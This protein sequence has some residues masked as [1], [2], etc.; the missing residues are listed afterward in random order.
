MS[1]IDDIEAAV[2]AQGT[3]IDGAI[4]LLTELHT[5]LSE[6]LEDDDQDR[7][8]AILDGLDAKR[9]QLA[10]AITANTPVSGTAGEGSV[11]PPSDVPA[12]ADPAPEGDAA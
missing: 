8:Q 1:K 7:L 6:A 3:V 10:E 4:S 5:E 9:N 2:A 11:P 12:P